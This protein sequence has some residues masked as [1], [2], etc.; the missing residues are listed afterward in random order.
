MNYNLPPLSE[1]ITKFNLKAR[2]SLGQNFILDLNVTK[3]I[4]QAA[5]NLTQ[6]HIIEIGPG[7]GALTRSLLQEKKKKVTTIETDKRF[8]PALEEIALAYPQRLDII[9]AD[10]LKINLKQFKPPYKIIANLPYNIA[11]RLLIL[12]L[13]QDPIEWTSLT[14]LFQKEVAMRICAKENDSAYGRLSI[15]TGWLTHAKILFD[16]SPKVFLPAPKVTSSLVH[17]TPRKEIDPS[18]SLPILEEL[19]A[20][21]FGKRRKMLRGSLKKLSSNPK[22]LLEIAKIDPTRRAETLTIEE[23]CSL[24]RLLEKEN[25]GL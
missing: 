12:W 15:L 25:Q 18:V 1:V 21:A 23:F 7:P 14:L 24:V 6:H 20:T 10:A 11:T 2:K 4:A 9:C 3:R 8:L 13:K 16:I 17:L 22:H 5:G 19:T